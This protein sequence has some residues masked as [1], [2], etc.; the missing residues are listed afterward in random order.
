MPKNNVKIPVPEYI[1]A[2]LC[3]KYG[4]DHFDITKGTSSPARLAFASLEVNPPDTPVVSTPNKYIHIY[5]GNSPKLHKVIASSAPMWRLGLYYSTEFWQGLDNWV[6]AT[7]YM[8]YSKFGQ[9]AN[10]KWNVYRAIEEFLKFYQID[11][12]LDVDSAYR[13][14]SRKRNQT[15][16]FISQYVVNR[17]GFVLASDQHPHKL[18]RSAIW[19]TKD[20]AS[21]RRIVFDAYSISKGRVIRKTISPPSTIADKE[22]FFLKGVSTINSYLNQGYCLQ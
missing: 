7:N 12:L 17:V 19:G 10:I 14:F 8:I 16:S 2:F 11:E 18:A 22:A 15:F 13:M 21:R 20:R 1:H 9:S 3:R 6:E 5:I 4:T